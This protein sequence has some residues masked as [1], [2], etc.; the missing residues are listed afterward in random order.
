MLVTALSPHIGYDKASKIARKADDEGTHPPRSSAGARRGRGRV[1]PHR[2]SE[3]HGRQSEA[4]P[5]PE[6][7]DL[8]ADNRERR[9]AR[10]R[11]E[12]LFSVCLRA[13]ESASAVEALD[14]IAGCNRAVAPGVGRVAV[15]AELD[16]NGFRG[17]TNAERGAARGAANIDQ[18]QR[19]MLR[20]EI[21]FLW[22]DG[23][24]L[25]P[26]PSFIQRRETGRCFRCHRTRP[27][28]ANAS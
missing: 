6:R 21:S 13:R 7:R 26:M 16:R 11:A 28:V 23:A 12:S 25:R 8:I 24:R 5:R 22:D 17:G 1:R 10:R 27:R 3:D 4:R 20:H 19:W 2:R 9:E 18:M 14:A 15:R